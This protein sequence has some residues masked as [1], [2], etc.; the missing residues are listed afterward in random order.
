MDLEKKD[1][2]ESKSI[3]F[4]GQVAREFDPVIVHRESGTQLNL[5][6]E[7]EKLFVPQF[8][9]KKNWLIPRKEWENFKHGKK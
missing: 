3:W 8:D 4:V 2:K 5:F 9:G 7:I 1:K 6:E